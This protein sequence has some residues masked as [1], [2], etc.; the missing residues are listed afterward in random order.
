MREME[1]NTPPTVP[2]TAKQKRI[3]DFNTN[4][5]SALAESDNVE[6][7]STCQVCPAYW[8]LHKNK[9]Y[10][11]QS[12]HRIKNWSDSRNDCTARNSHLLV[13]KDKEVLDFLTKFTQDKHYPYWIG[14]SLSQ[15]ENKWMWITGSQMDRNITQE[16]NHDEGQYCGA[17]RNSKILADICSIEFRWICQQDT[18]LI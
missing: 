18:I 6:L 17:I 14:L 5:F 10:W 16:P 4:H 8:F 12:D 3:A 7:N 13:I 2:P 1:D 15:P 11:W 9:C